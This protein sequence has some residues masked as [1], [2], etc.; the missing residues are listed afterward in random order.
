MTTSAVTMVRETNRS[1]LDFSTRSSASK[2]SLS[3][4]KLAM[5]ATTSPN[6]RPTWSTHRTTPMNISLETRLLFAAL[7]F[8]LVWLLTPHKIPPAEWI[9][10]GTSRLE[11]P[12]S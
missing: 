9:E 6:E 12:G 2:P 5:S 3:Q 1:M 4:Y 8:A 11:K 10:S 7:V